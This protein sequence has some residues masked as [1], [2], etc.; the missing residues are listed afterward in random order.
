MKCCFGPIPQSICFGRFRVAARRQGALVRSAYPKLVLESTSATTT[1]T[2]DSFRAGGDGGG[3]HSALMHHHRSVASSSASSALK[4]S[5][6]TRAVHLTLGVAVLSR[7]VGFRMPVSMADS[8]KQAMCKLF[9]MFIGQFAH[10]LVVLFFSLLGGVQ[11]FA[12]IKMLGLLKEDMSPHQN[13]WAWYGYQVIDLDRLT[14]DLG[15]PCTIH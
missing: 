7:W 8:F 4:R 1:A 11:L 2:G 6:L 13:E 5:P 9:T 14:V 3:G 15:A 10:V 12:M